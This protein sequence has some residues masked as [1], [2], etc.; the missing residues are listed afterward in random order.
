MESEVKEFDFDPIR[1]FRNEEVPAAIARLM[2][3]PSFHKALKFIFPEVS[4]ELMQQKFSHIKSVDDFQEKIVAQAVSKIISGTT[5]GISINGL[6]KLNKNNSYLFISN[7]RDI[8]LDSA[9]LNYQLFSN[10]FP[11]TRIAIGSNLLQKPW[12]EDLVK[13]NKNFIVHR[14]VHSKLAYVYSMRLS[15]FI[16]HSLADENSSVWIAQ[17][18]GRAKDGNDRTHAGLIKMFGMVSDWSKPAEFYN[19]LRISP[20]SISYEFEPC[21][22]YKAREMFMRYQSGV[23]QK[24]DGEDLQSM[25]SGISANKGKVHFEFSQS[26]NYIDI[27]NC[28]KG[29]SKNE[30][31]KNLALLIDNYVIGNYKL[32]PSNYIAYY[33]LTADTKFNDYFNEA[34]RIE[35]EEMVEFELAGF[36]FAPEMLKPYLLR[37]YANPVISKIQLK[38]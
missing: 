20:V 3:Q 15:R 35:F 32:F 5:N 34:Q 12:I 4:A 14:D 17:K 10:D 1:P 37:I 11:T 6:D 9:F 21:G 18:E 30:G 26:L 33:M 25:Q 23:Y 31:V 28:F 16:Q 7:H 24:Q 13:L 2:E 36:E 29:F 22:G 19:Q 8:V 27:N 38:K